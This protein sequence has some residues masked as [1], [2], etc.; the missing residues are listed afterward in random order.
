MV[1]F[2]PIR[3]VSLSLFPLNPTTTSTLLYAPAIIAVAGVCGGAWVLLKHTPEERE[4]YINGSIMSSR[5]SFDHLSTWSGSVDR[6]RPLAMKFHPEWRHQQCKV[7]RWYEEQSPPSRKFRSLEHR[8]DVNPPFYHEFLLFKLGEGVCRLERVGEGS[9][10]DAIM[11]AGCTANDIIRWFEVDNYNEYESMHPSEL[12]SEVDLLSE[13]DILDVLAICYSIQKTSPGNVYTLQRYNCYFLCLTV[14]TVLARR[15]A[16]WEAEMTHHIWDW[17]LDRVLAHLPGPPAQEAGEHQILQICA[18]LYPNDPRSSEFLLEEVYSQLRFNNE[19]VSD[20][21]RAVRSALWLGLWEP[22]D[23]LETAT[24]C[25]SA[26]LTE[27]K[28]SSIRFRNIFSGSQPGP[29]VIEAQRPELRQILLDQ[30]E[31]FWSLYQIMGTEWLVPFRAL[32]IW[33]ICQNF[34]VVFMAAIHSAL[35]Q[36]PGYM[37]TVAC[38]LHLLKFNPEPIGLDMGI[39]EPLRHFM[40]STLLSTLKEVLKWQ[41]EHITVKVRVRDINRTVDFQQQYVQARIHAHAKRVATLQLADSPLVYK[42]IHNAITA[43]WRSLPPDFGRVA[44]ND[45]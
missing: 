6:A 31:G 15:A 34:L 25:I 24:T 3:G 38:N 16:S 36:A 39:I 23:L 13:H 20:L 41:P 37:I 22:E 7:L 32:M 18:R 42:D 5:A 1:D 43:V 44:S 9:R 28:L 33:W 12:I 14:L 2:T 40:L 8:R 26:L 19:I 27:E 21:R 17:S 10:T 35:A 11:A 4:S 45:S 30:I 29:V